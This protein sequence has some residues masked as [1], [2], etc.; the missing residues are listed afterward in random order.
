VGTATSTAEGHQE[1]ALILEE[2]VKEIP[3]PV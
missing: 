2:I 1:A 3:V